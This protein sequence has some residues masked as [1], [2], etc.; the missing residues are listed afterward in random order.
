MPHETDSYLPLVNV[1]QLNPDGAT[2]TLR[3][4][5]NGKRRHVNPQRVRIS[6]AEPCRSCFVIEGATAHDSRPV[7]RWDIRYPIKGQMF[8]ADLPPDFDATTTTLLLRMVEGSEP[9]VIYSGNAND[10]GN[11]KDANA[12]ELE[13][14][15]PHFLAERDASPVE[16]MR[17]RLASH[18]V[19]TEFNWTAGNVLDGIMGGLY[20]DAE[21]RA[22]ARYYLSNYIDFDGV[23]ANNPGRCPRYGVEDT[24]PFA[25]IARLAPEHP[26]IDIVRAFWK[27]RAD[28]R[29]C[30]IEH[31]RAVAEGNYTV[32]YPKAVIARTRRDE[33]LARDALTELT[34]RREQLVTS[35]GIWL[36]AAHAGNPRTYLNWA[37]GVAWYYLGLSATL[38]ELHA[39]GF[40]MGD[41][42]DELLR[43]TDWIC[44]WQRADGLWGGFLHEVNTR[45][46]TSGSSG[47]AAGLA[48]GLHAGLLPSRFRENARRAVAGLER[49]L[50]PDGFLS[51]AT[52]RNVHEAGEAFQRSDYRIISTYATGL[53]ALALGRLKN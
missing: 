33:A 41:L 45:A 53:F 32:A 44:G 22:I 36:R 26:Q 47:I 14:F 27:S 10:A 18:T 1:V 21:A 49:F 25:T 8:E 6:V 17:R 43:A 9:L 51:G 23:D 5:T 15:Y 39:G 52:Q 2:Y 7:C 35:E 50:T 24:A 31:G 46:E 20:P 37:R 42:K 38:A 3:F 16:E 13:F 11:A 48:I 19:L 30:T 12:A 29:G 34:I 28:A 4:A 40:D